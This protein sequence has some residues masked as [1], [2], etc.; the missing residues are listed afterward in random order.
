M[1]FYLNTSWTEFFN[2]KSLRSNIKIFKKDKINIPKIYS[3]SGRQECY[4]NSKKN[5]LM[6]NHTEKIKCY[7][8]TNCHLKLKYS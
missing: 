7:R 3:I 2:D 8:I 5:C 1:K 4:K 6:T